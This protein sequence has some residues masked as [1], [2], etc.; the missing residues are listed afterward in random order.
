[1]TNPDNRLQSDTSYEHF[2][3]L[4]TPSDDEIHAEEMRIER[5]IDMAQDELVEDS[6]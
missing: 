1:M 5:E 2:Y 3:G 4:D 6:R